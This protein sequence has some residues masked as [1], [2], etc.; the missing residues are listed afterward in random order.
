MGFYDVRCGA[1]GL[2]LK[3]AG[4]GLFL[5]RQH[6][7][8][9]APVAL[10]VFGQY[11][12]LGAIDMIR[13]DYN[14]ALLYRKLERLIDEEELVLSGDALDQ[15]ER[16]PPSNIERVLQ[17]IERACTIKKEFV[18]YHGKP[19]VFML[20]SDLIYQAVTE[21]AA[22]DLKQ[23]EWGAALEALP[24]PEL[25]ERAFGGVE[26]AS[27]FYG[28]L[29][30]A[31]QETQEQARRDLAAF[32]RFR[33]WF[34]SWGKW[35]HDSSPSQHYDEHLRR[36]LRAAWK[37][38]K[39]EPALLRALARYAKSQEIPLKVLGETAPLSSLL[40]EEP[41]ARPDPS[42]PVPPVGGRVRHP[43][44]GEGTITEIS[45]IPGSRDDALK[46]TVRFDENGT[47]LMLASFLEVLP[48]A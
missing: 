44:F 13:E 17:A 15:Y 41:P 36:Y 27:T 40:R 16:D 46:F 47:K 45:G 32:I 18:T 14:T 23:P 35:K 6:N 1:S 9:F 3:G 43:K 20:V 10:P 30:G 12:R 24:L 11:N 37:R 31:P 33:A 4:A 2:S 22:Q 7:R 8:G 5:L 39:E 26:P 25:V 42:I 19:L 29:I 28:D 48:P 34:A 21:K 38:F